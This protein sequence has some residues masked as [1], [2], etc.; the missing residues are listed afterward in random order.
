[1]ITPEDEVEHLPIKCVLSTLSHVLTVTGVCVCARSCLNLCVRQTDAITRK[2]F[3]LKYI[4]FKVL[5]DQVTVLFQASLCEVFL[6][7]A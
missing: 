2:R 6:N 4:N 5:V 1:M 7:A 3:C